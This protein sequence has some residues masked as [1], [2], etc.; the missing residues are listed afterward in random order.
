VRGAAEGSAAG[1]SFQGWIAMTMIATFS[2]AAAHPAT[3]LPLRLAGSVRFERRTLALASAAVLLGLSAAAVLA[4]QTPPLPETPATPPAAASPAPTPS[5]PG[6]AKPSP[7]VASWQQAL[8]ARLD[9]I[10]SY[11]PQAN[12]AE[13]VVTVGFRIDRQGKVV[14]SQVVKSSGSSVL[15]AAALALIKRASPFPPPPAELSDGDLSI[16]VPIRYAAADKG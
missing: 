15:D 5:P 14:T 2:F 12:G 11:P 4:Q 1:P 8:V 10:K 16:V 3:T 13:G 9:R 7:A 6:P